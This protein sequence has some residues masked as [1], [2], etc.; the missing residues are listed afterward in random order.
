ME[1]DDKLSSR[2]PR[3][4][5]SYEKLWRLSFDVKKILYKYNLFVTRL[6]CSPPHKKPE[7]DLPGL[8]DN[9]KTPLLIISLEASSD[10]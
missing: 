2:I 3:A 9:E 7:Q 1:E 6:F 4:I 10:F 5:L 8:L